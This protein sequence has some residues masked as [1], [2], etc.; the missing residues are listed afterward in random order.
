MLNAHLK[1]FVFTDFLKDGDDD[2][3]WATP[4]RDFYNYGATTEKAVCL[5][6]HHQPSFC[7]RWDLEKV[8]P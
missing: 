6:G 7:S 5:P 3:R 2:T 8:L 1:S 4:G